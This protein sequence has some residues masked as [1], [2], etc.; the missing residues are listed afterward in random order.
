[1]TTPIS[2]S[3]GDS[4]FLGDIPFIAHCFGVLSD[5]DT[6]DQ[7]SASL[8]IFGSNG[9]LS[10]AALMGPTGPAGSSAPV[11]KL[12]FIVFDSE[13]DLPTNLT[14]DD[15]DIG[16]YWIVRVFDDNANEIGS[17][18]YIWYGD[19][20]ERFHMGTA[21]PVGPVPKVTFTFELVTSDVTPTTKV[22]KTGDNFNPSILVQINKELIRGPQ[23]VMGE[24]EELSNWNGAAPAETGDV[25]TFNAATS[26]WE[27]RSYQALVPK[28]YTM[29][30]AA[31]IDVP[32]GFGTSIP[33]GTFI[34][35]VQD[36][37][38][39]PYVQGHVRITGV[40]L[41]TDPLIVG[42]E[43]RLGSASTGQVVARG[44]GNIS[45][46][47][48]LMPH[49]STSATPN[50]AIAPGN[51]RGVITAGAT[52]PAATLYI[53]AFNDGVAGIYNFEKRG[54]QISILLVPV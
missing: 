5:L 25:P 22:T 1:M 44:F 48:N 42:A 32:L 54:A 4:V 3:M 43:V 20:Y 33:L 27:P 53:N 28:F 15:V 39:V 12:Q 7:V 9:S 40:E 38:C 23:G 24:M 17:N 36:F 34:V 26:E 6:P 16:K 14:E 19:H 45:T 37:D 11:G 31:F 50:D 47:V 52:G 8:E 46:Y 2:P 51:G 49:A 13:D 10:L 18:W 41:D 29:P 21:G 35:P 30:E